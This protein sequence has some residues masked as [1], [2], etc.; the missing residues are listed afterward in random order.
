MTSRIVIKFVLFFSVAQTQDTDFGLF[1][2]GLSRNTKMTEQTL[3]INVII[4]RENTEVAPGEDR[5]RNAVCR[6]WR[7]GRALDGEQGSALDPVLRPRRCAHLVAAPTS[8]GRGVSGAGTAVAPEGRSQEQTQLCGG[9]KWDIMASALIF[10]S[11]LPRSCLLRVEL[12]VTGGL[13]FCSG[14]FA[15]VDSKA[16]RIRRLKQDDSCNNFVSLVEGEQWELWAR[17][18]VRALTHVQLLRTNAGRFPETA[19][20]A[21]KGDLKLEISDIRDFHQPTNVVYSASCWLLR[22][23]KL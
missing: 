8:A 11:S 14:I 19:A 2:N 4:I 15:S 10:L 1:R 9:E 20:L 16:Q 7:L 22:S 17:A 21:T 23:P 3:I 18:C 6:A 5:A 13:V 12:R